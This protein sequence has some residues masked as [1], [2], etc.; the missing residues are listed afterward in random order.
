MLEE[1]LRCL[2]ALAE[3]RCLD[4]AARSCGI[5]RQDFLAVLVAAEQTF[6]R[7]LI[8][9]DKVFSEFTPLGEIVLKGARTL[10]QPNDPAK[11]A[12]K[13]PSAL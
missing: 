7:P 1:Q 2:L 10:D 6:G 9:F 3:T 11:I 5:S 8:H 13:R 12:P 4:A